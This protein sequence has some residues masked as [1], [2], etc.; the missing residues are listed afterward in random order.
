MLRDNCFSAGQDL[1][2]VVG[3]LGRDLG[4]VGF[5]TLRMH[6]SR[7][8]NDLSVNKQLISKVCEKKVRKIMKVNLNYEKSNNKKLAKHINQLHQIKVI[9]QSTRMPEERR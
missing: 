3:I 9:K 1:F 2:A 5:E 7:D 6:A 4:F 8:C